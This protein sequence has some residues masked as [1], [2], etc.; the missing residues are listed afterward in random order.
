MDI[1]VLAGGGGTRLWPLSDPARP[2]PFLPLLGD[3]TLIQRTVARLEPLVDASHVT[4]V[5]DVRYA[6]LVRQQ[7]PDVTIVAEPAGRN[8]AAAVALA[9]QSLKGSLDS[10]MV[11]L[12]ADHAIGDETTFVGMLPAAGMLATGGFGVPSPLVTFGIRPDHPATEYGYLVPRVED[13]AE[14]AGLMAYPLAAFVE[15]PDPARA[16][17]LLA[18][19]GTA[20]NAG[21]FLWRRRA[22]LDAFAQYA[23]DIATTIA[24]G[25][26]RDALATSYDEV[27][28]TSIDRAVMEPAAADGLVVMASADV[29]WSDLGSW[30][31]LLARLGARGTGRVVA[32]GEAAR[33][34][35]DDLVVERI[36][37]QL[38]LFDGPRDTLA[39]HPVAILEGT[40]PDREIVVALLSRTSAAEGTS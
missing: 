24:D 32:A 39:S 30:T 25:L 26:G 34:G 5:T 31:A 35:A 19:P 9:A 15:K 17:E 13:G 28:A 4:V 33:S 14:M 7:L 21:I 2:K 29:G 1:V 12:P 27:R 6:D 37:G 36:D 23:G 20:W 18:R 38:V 16:A 22:I 3:E 11:V 10:V 40:A 8:T